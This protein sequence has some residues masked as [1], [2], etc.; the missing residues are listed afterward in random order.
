VEAEPRSFDDIHR[1]LDS[2]KQSLIYMDAGD[3]TVH[4]TRAFADQISAIRLQLKRLMQDQRA[5]GLEI[6]RRA[7]GR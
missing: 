2:L 3:M 4:E 5:L 7:L 1:D 6:E